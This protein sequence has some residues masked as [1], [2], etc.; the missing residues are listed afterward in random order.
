MNNQ[1]YIHWVKL[2]GEKM[3]M[4][5][6]VFTP[7]IKTIEIKIFDNGKKTNEIKTRKYKRSI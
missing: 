3:P 7:E 5:M 6:I 1:M 4:A 2:R